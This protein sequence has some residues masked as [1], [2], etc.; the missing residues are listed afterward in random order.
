M[1]LLFH[2]HVQLH[3][4]SRQ[5]LSGPKDVTFLIGD[6]TL[7]SYPKG[8]TASE[9]QRDLAVYSVSVCVRVSE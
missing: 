9:K 3:R 6:T 2:P 4:L 7:K 1:K 8:A 5:L